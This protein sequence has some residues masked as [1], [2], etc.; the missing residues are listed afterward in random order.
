MAQS[1]NSKLGFNVTLRTFSL[2]ALVRE[3]WGSE[4][5]PQ[6]MA[7][8]AGQTTVHSTALTLALQESTG[9]P[10]IE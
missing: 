5:Q 10:A 8:I 7:S 6:T 3:E 2:N 4:S 1:V 9:S